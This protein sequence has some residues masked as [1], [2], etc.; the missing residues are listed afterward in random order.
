MAK[1]YS[2]KSREARRR[3]VKN[4]DEK[5]WRIYITLPKNFNE[6]VDAL[7]NGKSKSKFLQDIIIEKVR[8]IEQSIEEA[9]L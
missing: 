5:H 1:E 4:Y 3:A 9:R 8:E 6:R 2:E 7:R